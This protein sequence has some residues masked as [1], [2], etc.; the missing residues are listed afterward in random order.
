MSAAGK[1]HLI[2]D[3]RIDAPREAVWRALMTPEEWPQ[4]WRAV[5]SVEHI[6]DGDGNGVGAVRRMTWR[7]ALPYRLTFT[8]RMT[9]VE[10]MSLIEGRAEGEL[11][12][13]GRWTLS[14]DGARTNVRYE[15][16]VDVAKPWQ[17]L[18]APLLRPVFTWNHNKVMQWGQEGLA[19]KL[20][21]GRS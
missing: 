2:T 13:I 20:G 18:L 16:I 8:M 4:W 12:G 17:R 10:P 11:A 6:G 5:A 15:W 19:R 7:T 21:G 3:W 14:G 9:R 1:F